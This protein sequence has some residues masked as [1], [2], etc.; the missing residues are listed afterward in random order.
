MSFCIQAFDQKSSRFQIESITCK[1]YF[2]NFDCNCFASANENVT[3]NQNKVAFGQNEVAFGQNEVV[4][5][6]NEVVFGQNKVAFG[7][8]EVEA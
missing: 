8:N 3:F 2:F 5:G 1:R 7:Q 6:Q 4:F